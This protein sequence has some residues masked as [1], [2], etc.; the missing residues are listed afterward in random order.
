MSSVPHEV[1]LA[2]PIRVGAGTQRLLVRVGT[3][4][5]LLA[6][7]EGLVTWLAPSFVARPSGIARVLP[8]VLTQTNVP[9][10]T[11][12]FWGAAGVT[13]LAAFE[14]LLIGLALGVLVGLTMG[15]LRTVDRLLRFYLSA[16]FAMPII[17]LVPVMTL[18]FGYT[19]TVRL[20]IVSLGA[21]LPVCLQVYDG[22]RRLPASY[23]EVAQS[24]HARWWNVWFGIAL[25]ASLPYLLAGFRL[26][27]GRVLVGAVIAEYIVALKGLGY[28]ILFD[29]RAFHQNQMMV[30]VLFLALLGVA[31][32]AAADLATR[33]FLPWYRR[34]NG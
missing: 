19:G 9:P 20:V 14:G 15:R 23:V 22:T 10:G 24:Y 5:L 30:A 31:V 12:K 33:R 16:F 2:R 34:A 18:W 8:D 17:A 27:V 11:P 6:L 25:P 4:I 7:W 3:G 1:S 13:V 29:A 32:N 21:F 28:F 26:A